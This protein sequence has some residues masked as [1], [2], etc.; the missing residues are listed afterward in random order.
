MAERRAPRFEEVNRAIDAD[1]LPFAK[2]LPPFS[3]LI[4]ELDLSH[5]LEPTSVGY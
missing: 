4:C 1:L 5:A 2:S 3:E